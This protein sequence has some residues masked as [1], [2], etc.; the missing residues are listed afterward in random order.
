MHQ[1]RTIVVDDP[2]VCQAVS[3]AECLKTAEQIDVLFG[4]NTSADPRNIVSDGSPYP[5]RQGEKV[6]CGLYQITLSVCF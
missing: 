2:S 5:P 6:R 4:V 3:R 1:M